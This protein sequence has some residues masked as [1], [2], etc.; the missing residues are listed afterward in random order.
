MKVNILKSIAAIIAGIIVGAGLSVGTDFLLEKLGIFPPS[1][2][3]L[4]VWWMLLIALIYRSVYTIVSGY[5][6]ALLA[7]ANP[8]RHAIILGVIGVVVSILG[9]IVNWDKSAAWYPIALI[10]VTLPCSWIGG[11][12]KVKNKQ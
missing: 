11:R 8:L 10:L 4:F 6:T 12:L 1:T 7:P 9:T 2:E 3:G 5:V